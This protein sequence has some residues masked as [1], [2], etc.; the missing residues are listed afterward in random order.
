[1]SNLDLKQCDLV[2]FQ[3]KIILRLGVWD[4]P[5]IL[6]E[7][8]QAE[9][10]SSPPVRHPNDRDFIIDYGLSMVRYSKLCQVKGPVKFRT[11]EYSFHV[12]RIFKIVIPSVYFKFI[13]RF[14]NE[15]GYN[16]MKRILLEERF[17]RLFSVW[18]KFL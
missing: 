13:G 2:G 1:M 9:S 7:H 5:A 18:I 3:E 12:Q 11:T 10:F 15:D 4:V 14:F 8:I 17:S 6:F 16:N